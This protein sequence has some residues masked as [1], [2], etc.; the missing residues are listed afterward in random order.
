[1]VLLIRTR[2]SIKA[3]QDF[4]EKELRKRAAEKKASAFSD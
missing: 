2:M 1:M 3:N 4:I